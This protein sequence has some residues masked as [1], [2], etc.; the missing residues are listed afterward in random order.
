M[1]KYQCLTIDNYQFVDSDVCFLRDPQDVLNPFSGFI[2]SCG[3]WNNPGDTCTEES[4]RLMRMK[5]T[6]WQRKVFNVGQFACDRALYSAQ[7]LITTAMRPE[8][9]NTCTKFVFHEQPGLNMLVFASGTEITNLTLPP[10]CMESTWA[11]DY[12]N[13]YER[14]WTDP[15]RKPYLI[16]WAGIRMDTNRPIHRIFYNYLTA[17]EKAEWDEQ[18]RISSIKRRKQNSSFKAIA[19]R[20]KRAMQVLTQDGWPY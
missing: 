4:L 18:V 3:H 12:D 8:F 10:L 2:T 9:L 16:H 1:R 5:T 14:Y 6:T 7:S 15:K 20:F 13:E 19:R 17:A 11:G